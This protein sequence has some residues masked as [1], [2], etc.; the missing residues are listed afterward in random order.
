MGE[1]LGVGISD[2]IGLLV[3]AIIFGGFLGFV[4]TWGSL[5]GVA[6]GVLAMIVVTVLYVVLASDLY[7]EPPSAH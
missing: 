3:I 1:V 5:G 4:L 6:I 7:V 2:W